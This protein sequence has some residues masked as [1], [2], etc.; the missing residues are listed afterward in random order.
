M[1]DGSPAVTV[2]IPTYNHAHFLK[3]AL[4]SVIN[5]TF[6]NWE[7]IVI[8]NFSEDNTIEV[9]NGFADPRIR[10]INYHN[11]GIIASSR[12]EGIRAAKADLIAFLDS[13][14][15]WHPLKLERC[16][17]KLTPNIDLVCHGLRFIKDGVFW[18][19][20][21]YG[22]E[23]KARFDSLLYRGNALTPSAVLLRKQCLLKVGG[24]TE[25]INYVTAEDYDLWLKLAKE[26]IH[27]HFIDDIL[28]DY[29]LHNENASKAVLRQMKASL[30]VVNYHFNTNTITFWRHI[31]IR[32]RR[33]LILYGAAR[34]FQKS[35]QYIEALQYLGKSF[36]MF[37]FIIRLYAAL[38]INVFL[39][40]KTKFH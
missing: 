4:Q 24:F 16:L 28:G 3:N 7:A 38:I 19:E 21:K 5:Q 11:H 31:K 15:L 2:V 22:P 33:G 40:I 27:F 29:Q 18:R 34:G 30:E 39:I 37:P 20:M 36:I 9:V 1:I 6:M 23:K 10:L 26:K 25:D 12:N 35:G 13:D 32:Y 8:N 14:D 17:E